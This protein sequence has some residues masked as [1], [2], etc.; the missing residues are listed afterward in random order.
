[1]GDLLGWTYGERP[2]CE[3]VRLIMS[4]RRHMFSTIERRKDPVSRFGRSQG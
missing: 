4:D 1:M 2:V 3:V